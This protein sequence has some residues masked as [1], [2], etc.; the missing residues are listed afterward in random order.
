MGALLLPESLRWL[1]FALGVVLL[2]ATMASVAVTLIMPRARRSRLAS[3]AGSTSRYVVVRASRIA[4]TYERQDALLAAVAPV[5]LLSLLMSWFVLALFGWTLLNW[6][7]IHLGIWQAL[8]ETGSSAFT[9]GFASTNRPGPTLVDFGAAATGPLIVALQISYLP[10][11]YNAFNRRET[12]VTL[13]ASRAGSPPWGPEIL[14]RH[15]FFGLFDQLP[16]FYAEWERWSAEV[17]ESHTS[18]RTLLYFRSPAPWR[19]WVVSLLAVLDSAALLHAVAPSQ[20]PTQARLCLQ[21]G[22]TCFRDLA[23]AFSLPYD[24]DPDPDESSLILSYEEFLVGYNTVVEVGIV[25]ERGP[26]EAWLHFKGWRVNYE[27]A[28]YGLAERVLAPPAPWSGPRRGLVGKISLPGPVVH[29]APG[30][31]RYSEPGSDAFG[32]GSD[33]SG[34]GSD[35]SG[36]EREPPGS[37]EHKLG[38]LGLK[39]ERSS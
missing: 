37:P 24:P 32:S 28:A 20:A 19:S 1:G 26:D 6:P 27:Q 38:A 35:A 18:Y 5:M 33:A 34:S 36:S 10:T 25:V 31:G 9:L 17:A 16:A 39:P 22:L 23:R 12:L 13:L 7:L 21:M 2:V 3:L 29:R 14:R 11:L 30:G 4:R 15:R 8:R